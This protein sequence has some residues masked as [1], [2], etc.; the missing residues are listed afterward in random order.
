MVDK[1]LEEKAD[2]A[3]DDNK[4]DGLYEEERFKV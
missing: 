4:S 1:F 2:M 3:E